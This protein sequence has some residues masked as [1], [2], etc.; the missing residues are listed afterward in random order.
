MKPKLLKLT[1]FLLLF[2]GIFSA[3]HKPDDPQEPDIIYPINVSFT[4]YYLDETSCQ[5]VNLPY[6]EKAIV[7]NSDEELE[8]YLSCMEGFYPVIDFSEN[9]LI[10]ISGQTTTGI[11]HIYKKLAQLSA[12]HIKLE[13][14]IELDA[15]PAKT[16]C[17]ALITNKITE[18]NAL[19]SNVTYKESIYPINVPYEEFNYK[20][21][22]K[23][24]YDA[25][26]LLV[27][28]SIEELE[29]NIILGVDSSYLDIDFSKYTVWVANGTSPDYWHS[30]NVGIQQLSSKKYRFNVDV[31]HGGPQ[32]PSYWRLQ[33]IT[34]KIEEN[35]QVE[36]H[37]TY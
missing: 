7:I 26:M 35:A 31:E 2:A 24:Y 5:W 23:I 1:A 4:D 33:V 8:N 25:T 27:I 9:S 36:Y 3:C 14:N 28:N 19:E 15:T 13:I 17:V 10:L 30:L 12:T 16:W 37:V 34:N 32:T 29:E 18:E 21:Y 6:D 20:C 22:W 11:E